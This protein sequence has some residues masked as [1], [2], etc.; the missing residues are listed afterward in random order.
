ML[1]FYSK[2]YSLTTVSRAMQQ[3]TGAGFVLFCL[4]LFSLPHPV[5]FLSSILNCRNSS[6]KIY[7]PECCFLPTELKE[8]HGSAVVWTVMEQAEMKLE[9][10]LLVREEFILSLEA[11]SSRY[12]KSWAQ[13]P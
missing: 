4:Y 3:A 5:T 2:W 11:A 8:T 1:L 7:F 9:L 6:H 13:G 10:T 12:G